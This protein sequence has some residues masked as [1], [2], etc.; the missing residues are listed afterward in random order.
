MLMSTP[1]S[2]IRYFSVNF[3]KI[4]PD[5]ECYFR[6]HPA[7]PG[8]ADDGSDG[9]VDDDGTLDRDEVLPHTHFLSGDDENLIFHEHLWQHEI[10]AGKFNKYRHYPH[11]TV[12]EIQPPSRH[13]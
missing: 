9:D 2:E 1:W 4:T 6:S 3:H 11:A 12:E 13:A 8:V 7:G 10:G 5:G